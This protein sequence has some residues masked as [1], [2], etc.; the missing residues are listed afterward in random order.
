MKAQARSGQTGFAKHV[1]LY[2]V[3]LRSFLAHTHTCTHTHTL[4]HTRNLRINLLDDVAN[5]ELLAFGCTHHGASGRTP[6]LR[7]MLATRDLLIV[8]RVMRVIWV[9]RVIW[10]RVIWVMRVIWVIVMRVIWVIWVTW[11]RVI[12]VIVI[13]FVIVMRVVC[14]ILS[15]GCGIQVLEKRSPE[16]PVASQTRGTGGAGRYQRLRKELVL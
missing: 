10:V 7:V 1:V 2:A 8:M 6:P 14:H 13:I 16:V 11:V 4:T 15:S 9:I 3:R 5:L 12:W